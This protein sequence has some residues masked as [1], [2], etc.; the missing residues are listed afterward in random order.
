MNAAYQHWLERA[1]YDPDR[2]RELEK[3]RQDPAAVSARF[4]RDLGFGTGGS[5]AE[6]E[7]LS[8]LHR[9][10]GR[11]RHLADPSASKIT[12]QGHWT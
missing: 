9:L 2:T 10:Y 3:I 11:R 6:P 8:A 7:S 5:E 4:Y 1:V 12:G